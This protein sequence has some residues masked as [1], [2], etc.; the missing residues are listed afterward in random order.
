MWTNATAHPSER[1][2][3]LGSLEASS[4]ASFH[5]QGRLF[6]VRSYLRTHC[7]GQACCC[8]MSTGSENPV[9]RSIREATRSR[10][11]LAMVGGPALGRGL[12]RAARRSRS[13]VSHPSPELTLDPFVLLCRLVLEALKSLE[14]TLSLDHLSY[15]FRSQRADQLV[16]QV[17]HQRRL[18]GSTNPVTPPFCV[19]PPYD[20]VIEID[21]ERL[22]HPGLCPSVSIRVRT[23]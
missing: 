12:R 19:D 11:H 17:A 13:W 6:G 2:G 4:A 21:T 3:H 16:L 22:S 9:G 7:R 5:P 18:V 1:G 15:T 14:L 20:V 10:V 23:W 8:G